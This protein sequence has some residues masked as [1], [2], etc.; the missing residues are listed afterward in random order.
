MIFLIIPIWIAVI[1]AV[2]SAI[3]AYGVLSWAFVVTKCWLWFV[4]AHFGLAAIAMPQAICLVVL[5]GLVKTLIN[6][7]WDSILSAFKKEEPKEGEQ[8]KWVKPTVILTAPW[9]ILGF[10][11]LI[12]TVFL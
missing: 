8:P 1:A 3:V 5:C 10:Y 12:K 2:F 4:T 7:E 9:L 11:W 6:P